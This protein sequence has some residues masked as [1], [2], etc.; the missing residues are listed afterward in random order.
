MLFHYLI[1][2]EEARA[3]LLEIYFKNHDSTDC[4]GIAQLD[5]PFWNIKLGRHTET[6]AGF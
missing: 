5:I 1:G 6:A 2:L 3:K 4:R